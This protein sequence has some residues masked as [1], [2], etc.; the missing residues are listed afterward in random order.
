M[1]RRELVE[2]PGEIKSPSA[3]Y[4]S[5]ALSLSYDSVFQFCTGSRLTFSISESK[6]PL[7]L[8]TS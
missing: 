3:D 1:N 7:P 5:A 4:E 6:K 8:R 2:L